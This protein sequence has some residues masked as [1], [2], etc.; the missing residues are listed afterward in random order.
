M[1]SELLAKLQTYVRQT[2]SQYQRYLVRS[3]EY[4]E[5]AGFDPRGFRVSTAQLLEPTMTATPVGR[6]EIAANQ[7]GYF[8][9]GIQRSWLLYTQNYSPVYYGYVAAVI[10]ARPDSRLITW[11]Y[12]YAEGL[13]LSFSQLA[14]PELAEL[15]RLGIQ[16]HDLG[17]SEPQF[18]LQKEKAVEMI[19]KQR[20]RLEAE[21][22]KTWIQ[23]HGVGDR[24]LVV[25]G[26][27]SISQ[28][29]AAHPRLVGL[30]KSH[31]TQYFSFPDQGVI[32][33]L[34]FGDRSSLF[35]PKGRYPLTS[36]YL[37][38]RDAKH[39]DQYFGLIRVEVA[40]QSAALANQISQWILTERRPLALPDQR[41]DKMIYPIRDCEQFLRAKEP[42]RASFGWLG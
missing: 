35:Q 41:W 24:W 40:N 12:Q 31:N 1:S 28:L 18:N 21:L 9:D 8:M 27:L 30:I 25:D 6:C 7:F 19:T 22:I 14:P 33:Q 16:L 17:I 42:S 20:S 23:H 3:P 26:S 29:G 34:Q 39:Q 37:R 10:R 11:R 5:Q 4:E 32:L 2:Q 13:Y 36:W 15:A 38:M